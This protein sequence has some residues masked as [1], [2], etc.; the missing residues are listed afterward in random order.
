MILHIQ[1]QKADEKMA[2]II[3]EKYFG[4]RSSKRLHY[5]FNTKPWIKKRKYPQT[6][7]IVTGTGR[8]LIILHMRSRL[9]VTIKV[10][11]QLHLRKWNV[12]ASKGR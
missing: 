2:F 8:E 4:C 11:D 6:A 1:L 12:A 5:I 10:Y 3:E 9:R 7:F